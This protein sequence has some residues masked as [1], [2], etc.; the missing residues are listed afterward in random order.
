MTVAQEITSCANALFDVAGATKLLD[1]SRL[2]IVDL[3]STP[4]RDLDEFRLKVGNCQLSGFERYALPKLESLLNF[5]RKQ[6]FTAEPAGRYGYPL[7]GEIN[8]KEA[9]VRAGLGNWG[10]GQ[11]ILTKK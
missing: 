1:G 7:R 3:E 11:R 5:I 8:L 6:S 4:E 10:G 2:L 9:A